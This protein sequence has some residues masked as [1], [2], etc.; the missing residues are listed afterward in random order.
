M[1]SCL[2]VKDVG[3]KDIVARVRTHPE[4]AR[5]DYRNP[6]K[7]CHISR[8]HHNRYNN[9]VGPRFLEE[10]TFTYYMICVFTGALIPCNCLRKTR[11]RVFPPK[12]N[13]TKNVPA[14]EKLD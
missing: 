12:R 8:I 7:A 14:L 11:L 6:P 5:K 2:N 3:E 4:F 9:L 1:K 13:W 10:R